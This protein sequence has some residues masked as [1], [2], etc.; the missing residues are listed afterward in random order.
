MQDFADRSFTTLSGGEKQ[1]V[2]IARALVQQAKLLVLDEPTNHLDI[3]SQLQIMAILKKLRCT[4]LT[5]LHDL[6]IA[7]VYCDRLYIVKSGEIVASGTPAEVLQ[8][9]LINDVFG[10]EC[11]V[12]IHPRT[13]KPHIVFLS[14]TDR[15][16]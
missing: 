7:A 9:Q 16:I 6:N 8:P 12:S 14:A 11:E 10:V 4:V 13:S 2:L 5:A 1:R 15:A 3:H